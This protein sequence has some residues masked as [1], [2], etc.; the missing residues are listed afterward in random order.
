VD[1]ARALGTSHTTIY[2]H[3]RSMA[4]IFD[5]VARQAMQD[6]EEMAQ[7]FVASDAPAGEHLEGLV[8]ALLARKR[9]RLADDPE[10]F[11]LYRRVL[12]ERP[13]LIAAYAAAMTALAERIL[14]DGARRG[15]FRF[16]DVA[17]AAGVVRDA[18]TA[19]LHPAHVAAAA[20]A[21]LPV[22]ALA[23]NVVRTL[24]AGFHQGVAFKAPD[25]G[26]RKAR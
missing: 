20:R 1:I 4:E 14:E 3:F 24:L 11:G 16:D 13:D 8:L 26:R 9:A 18:V 6:E 12:E 10:V 7:R 25:G 23:R 19:F 2:R 21:G 17:A 22:E 15:E 5:A